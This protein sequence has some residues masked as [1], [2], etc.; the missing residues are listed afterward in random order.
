MFRTCWDTARL[1]AAMVFRAV[2]A[3]MTT[4]DAFPGIA[5]PTTIVN[6]GIVFLG[7]FLS[8][9]RAVSGTVLAEGA[10]YDGLVN[11]G[12]VVFAAGLTAASAEHIQPVYIA[13]P[14]IV[15][16]LVHILM[17]IRVLREWSLARAEDVVDRILQLTTDAA[18]LGRLR[19]GLVRLERRYS[20]QLSILSSSDITPVL[21]QD[22]PIER[23]FT[24]LVEM[25]LINADF[26][27][28]GLI[29]RHSRVK[30]AVEANEALTASQ[31]SLVLGSRT[32]QPRTTVNE[33]QARN[34]RT[35]DPEHRMPS[36]VS[37]ASE[38]LFAWRPVPQRRPQS[39]FERICS[40]REAG[41]LPVSRP[42]RTQTPNA[43]SDATA[44][45][46]Y[47]PPVTVE[48]IAS[49]VVGT[50]DSP[51][52]PSTPFL[53]P[54]DIVIPVPVA[55]IAPL[56]VLATAIVP[57]SSRTEALELDPSELVRSAY[58][59]ISESQE[60][61][62]AQV[63]AHDDELTAVVGRRRF[64]FP[65]NPYRANIQLEYN[66][67]RSAV[68]Q[69]LA[70]P[71][72]VS[73]SAD[74]AVEISPLRR[75]E[76]S[77]AEVRAKLQSLL[78]EEQR[79]KEALAEVGAA[80]VAAELDLESAL[81]E[82]KVQRMQEQSPLEAERALLTFPLEDVAELGQE[83]TTVPP[84]RASEEPEAISPEVTEGEGEPAA[85]V[86]AA[87]SDPECTYR[88]EGEEVLAHVNSDT[89]ERPVVAP[90]THA[91]RDPSPAI[92]PQGEAVAI[93]AAHE[94]KGS[95][96]AARDPSAFI[97][98]PPQG[99]EGS[100]GSVSSIKVALE[101]VE[102]EQP[103]GE[104]ELVGDITSPVSLQEETPTVVSSIPLPTYDD[105]LVVP[106]L[107]SFACSS[108]DDELFSDDED[109]NNG[110]GDE[111]CRLPAIGAAS[112]TKCGHTDDRGEDVPMEIG[113]QSVIPSSDGDEGP[114]D[115]AMVEYPN[116]QVYPE[117]EIES[118][119][120]AGMPILVDGLDVSMVDSEAG[121]VLPT[122][123]T[124]MTE[125]LRPTG[126][127]EVV[128]P[129]SSFAT[130]ITRVPEDDPSVAIAT[131]GGSEG[132]LDVTMPEGL[133][134]P[135]AA[136]APA[137]APVVEMSRAVIPATPRT[138][139]AAPAVVDVQS[140]NPQ[141]SVRRPRALVVRDDVRAAL[142][143]EA[144]AAEEARAAFTP[145]APTAVIEDFAT[146]LRRARERQEVNAA[147]RLASQPSSEPQE[148]PSSSE[149]DTEEEEEEEDQVALFDSRCGTGATLSA[150]RI[151]DVEGSIARSEVSDEDEEVEDQSVSPEA[152]FTEVHGGGRHQEQEQ[153]A[154][155]AE[156]LPAQEA[157]LVV[158]PQPP[159]D[160]DRARRVQ[161]AAARLAS[162]AAASTRTKRWKRNA[163][164]I[165]A[166]ADIPR[167]IQVRAQLPE[168][169]V[170]PEERVQPLYPPE[171][172]STRIR[173]THV[174]SGSSP[175]S[176]SGPSGSGVR[177][178]PPEPSAAGPST[179]LRAPPPVV[180]PSG[181]VAVNSP[182]RQHLGGATTAAEMAAASD[183]ANRDRVQAMASAPIG[184]ATPST[185]AT[186]PDAVLARLRRPRP[187]SLF[188]QS[189]RS[190]PRK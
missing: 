154:G 42:P 56:D 152:G 23:T 141:R 25:L 64:S 139:T 49:P 45:V 38:S 98:S 63:M 7:V 151:P 65:T 17:S 155:E 97:P 1:V 8:T 58:R 93:S 102:D 27:T 78:A 149:V 100:P 185:P 82:E 103:T 9:L 118:L 76:E 53:P 168:G 186:P 161:E 177:A 14:L 130:T 94:I 156:A 67:R 28:R 136:P 50:T 3:T 52:D 35:T 19:T 117:Y 55:E 72:A 62:A 176:S 123:D 54:C 187:P 182:R 107:P 165:S 31:R 77:T 115:H 90:Q 166:R 66:V 153:T 32:D 121:S 73:D 124:E 133:T 80:H 181:L 157:M 37:A 96:A 15:C 86:V 104:A 128:A 41:L 70:A 163:A 87:P 81:A 44:L 110:L 170:Y 183:E 57:T 134:P 169:T 175:S 111:D 172:F 108:F 122:V 79:L 132:P 105:N 173:G 21:R 101:R 20:E 16:L 146:V 178:R 59:Q 5:L 127:A 4:Q 125:S 142:Q 112:P 83:Q 22:G 84:E 113:H 143:A 99:E 150:L 131:M 145:S 160:E 48:P 40:A 159:M 71:V 129:A 162:E 106:L 138:E 190:K 46:P 2:I 26:A 92:V 29:V 68:E 18:N 188:G 116:G 85:A 158:A 135:A 119:F 75:A 11:S 179:P 60:R 164:P 13:V 95:Q 61:F 34:R 167:D 43:N 51:S 184:R 47:V 91:A 174:L 109:V 144:R 120:L 180:A 189:A 39:L 74:P 10:Q 69:I 36:R 114:L 30:A 137:Q 88:Q 6:F 89:F 24:T 140:V 148:A 33:E 147:W 126:M 12:W 171:S